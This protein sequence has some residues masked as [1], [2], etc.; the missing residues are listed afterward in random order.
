MRIGIRPEII[1]NWILACTIKPVVTDRI[2]AAGNVFEKE[3][4]G[5][6]A[7][8]FLLPEDAGEQQ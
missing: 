6:I 5:M 1:M 2:P 3:T 7:R 8:G 4:P